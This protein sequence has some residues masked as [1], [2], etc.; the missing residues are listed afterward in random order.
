MLLG[1]LILHP[2]TLGFGA[3]AAVFNFTAFSLLITSIITCLAAAPT[4][5]YIDDEF[6]CLPDRGATGGAKAPMDTAS[7]VFDKV[8]EMHALMGVD[9]YPVDL[10]K[11][12]P[13]SNNIPILG[14]NI[15]V[16]DGGDF[17][18]AIPQKK[19][20]KILERIETGIRLELDRETAGKLAGQLCWVCFGTA[21]KVGNNYIKPLYAFSYG[22]AGPE[23][24]VIGL[25]WWRA[26]IGEIYPGQRLRCNFCSSSKWK[27]HL[28]FSDASDWY[29]GSLLFRSC[30]GEASVH[31]CTV[32]LPEEHLALETKLGSSTREAIGCL[33]TMVV[34]GPLLTDQRILNLC[35]NSGAECILGRSRAAG[36]I[37]LSNIAVVFHAVAEALGC[38]PWLTY[39]PGAF[40]IAD[41]CSRPVRGCK[42]WSEIFESLGFGFVTTSVEA[43]REVLG[44]LLR[45]KELLSHD[46]GIVARFSKLALFGCLDTATA[47]RWANGG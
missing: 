23:R 3:R 16:L 35:D 37:T 20:N 13:P 42:W 17:D 33:T 18:V 6:G 24:C 36:S 9:C 1:D 41:P 31:M 4:C 26:K 30:L 21:N 2:L 43:F 40:M 29:V 44:D 10:D 11:T 47:T 5:V 34:L 14:L 39:C 7:R 12:F 38:E 22:E 46:S 32:L 15:A 25:V 27:V 45:H 28:A 8:Q 19:R